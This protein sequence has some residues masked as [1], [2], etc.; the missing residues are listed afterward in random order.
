MCQQCIYTSARFV[1]YLPASVLLPWQLQY[2]PHLNRLRQ[3]KPSC[4]VQQKTYGLDVDAQQKMQHY[5]CCR[6]TQRL[7]TTYREVRMCSIRRIC[8]LYSTCVHVWSIGLFAQMLL[9]RREKKNYCKSYVLSKVNP[10]YTLVTQSLCSLPS[11]VFFSPTWK[12]L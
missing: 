5:F 1:A 12:G 3:R 10:L 8:S 9:V 4:C 2:I 11:C 6:L 7:P